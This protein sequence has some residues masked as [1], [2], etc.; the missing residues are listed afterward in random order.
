MG[1]NMNR[2]ED[3]NTRLQ[4]AKS[5][6]KR[7]TRSQRAKALFWNASSDEDVPVHRS[8][9]SSRGELSKHARIEQLP[10]DEI[11]QAT[12]NSV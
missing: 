2:S 11:K 6:R 3:P 5:E 12:T 9:C 8:V 10:I 1:Q 7:E 4:G